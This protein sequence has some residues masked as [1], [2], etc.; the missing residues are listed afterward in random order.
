MKIFLLVFS[1]IMIIPSSTVFAQ[2]ENHYSNGLP[3]GYYWQALDEL[4]KNNMIFGLLMGYEWGYADG[5]VSGNIKTG[6][7]PA[8]PMF[9]IR[10]KS[11]VHKIDSF[12]KTYPLCKKMDLLN[13]FGN[14]LS[15]FHKDLFKSSGNRNIRE[16]SYKQIGDMCIQASKH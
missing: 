6:V 15:F 4:T 2:G 5:V 7:P 16:I 11:Y 14:L 12:Y 3:N 10:P 13:V 1:L 8:M 9:F